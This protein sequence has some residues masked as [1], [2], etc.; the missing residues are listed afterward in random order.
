MSGHS[1]TTPSYTGYFAIY[2][3][4]AGL[5]FAAIGSTFMN[6]GTSALVV[7]LLIAGTQACLLAYFFMHLKTAD[8]LTW[9]IVGAALFWMSI[10]FVLLLTDYLTRHLGAY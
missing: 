9:L 7:N 6:L 4:I 8:N 2:I 10:L 3:A 5:I 1:E